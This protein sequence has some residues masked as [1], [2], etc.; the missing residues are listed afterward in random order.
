MIT[1]PDDDPDLDPD[2][3]LTVLLRP[4]ADHLGPPAGRYEAIRR[5]ATRR[6]LL[7]AAAGTAVVC[8]LAAAVLLPLRLSTSEAPASPT[9]PLAPPPASSSPT[10]PPST[11]PP[12]DGR[13]SDGQQPSAV[14]S[15]PATSVPVRPDAPS[16]SPSTAPTATA[17]PTPTEQLPTEQP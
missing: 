1:R 3:P 11:P 6:K 5:G 16:P 8:G 7:R 2:D 9:V 17:E 12:S 10:A 4:P 14:P 15:A 13:P